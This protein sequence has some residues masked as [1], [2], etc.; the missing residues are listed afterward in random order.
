MI[1]GQ[2]QPQEAV[3]LEALREGRA[4]TLELIEDLTDEQMIGPRLDIVNPLRWEIGHVGWF[5]EY[6]ILRHSRQEA[7]TWADGDRLYD[8]ARIAH[9]T[10]WDL[11]LP[12]KMDTVAYIQRIL[13]RVEEPH[14]S[15]GSQ[16]AGE[17]GA[18]Q[19]AYFLWLA[20]LHE[21][22]HAEAIT[23]TR[24]TLGYSEPGSG[25]P[26]ALPAAV[27]AEIFWRVTGVFPATRKFP[28]ALS[29]SAALP[30]SHSFLIT[31]RTPTR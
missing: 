12:S 16:I 13:E 21:Y 14:A 23:Y 31:S 26:R 8:S 28:E 15:K 3:F 18:Y 24:Q 22:M 5:Q 4:R 29:C 20:L 1:F 11:P 2:G 17:R 6:W 9:D 30:M 25:S 27:D 10:R 19:E 7:P